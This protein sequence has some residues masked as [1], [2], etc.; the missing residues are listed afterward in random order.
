[1]APFVVQ[2]GNMRDFGVFDAQIVNVFFVNK[3]MAAEIGVQVGKD[4]KE[5]RL[6][7]NFLGQNRGNLP[8][9]GTLF[10]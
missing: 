9:Y 3:G 8:G 10:V 7:A 2:N 1:M 6:A 5:L 4:G